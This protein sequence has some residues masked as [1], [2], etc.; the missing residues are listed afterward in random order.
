VAFNINSAET[1]R[2][3]REIV[4]KTGETPTGAIQ[5]ALEERLDRIKRENDS[6]NLANQ[7]EEIL[8]RVDGPPVLDARSADE[9]IGYDENGLPH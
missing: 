2:L 1:E 5:R 8:K 4:A 6:R 9:I 7:L 3:V